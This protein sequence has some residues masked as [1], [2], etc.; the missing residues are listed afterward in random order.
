M[1]RGGVFGCDVEC[2][3]F[4]A[5]RDVV[6]ARLLSFSTMVKSD[7]EI[8]FGWKDGSENLKFV[9]M[10]CLGIKRIL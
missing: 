4:V 7:E 3:V 1:C 5:I 9:I 10:W 6:V 2:E 8:F